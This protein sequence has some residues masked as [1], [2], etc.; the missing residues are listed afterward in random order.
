MSP[1]SVSRQYPTHLLASGSLQVFVATTQPMV[2][3]HCGQDSG[4]QADMCDIA[5]DAHCN[6]VTP[7]PRSWGAVGPAA[8]QLPLPSPGH[9]I[10]G[11]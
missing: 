11:L 4:T 6:F 10:P 1:G 2:Q 9:R 7:S 8:S 3:R 5:R